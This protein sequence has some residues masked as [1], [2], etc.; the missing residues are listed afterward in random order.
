[1]NNKFKE[2]QSKFA[3]LEADLQNPALLG[4]SKKV[5]EVSQEYNELKPAME[6]IKELAGLEN[7]IAETELIIKGNDEEMREM[8][9]AEIHSFDMYGPEDAPLTIIAFG[10]TKLPVLE[11]MKWL[12]DEQITVNFL[13]VSSLL[14]FPSD[15]VAKTMQNAKKT[16][17]IE[18]NRS[19]QFE[20]IIKEHTGLSVSDRL[21]KYNGR[22]FYPEEIVA[23]VKQVVK[24]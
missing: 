1:M 8:A 16:L 22:P 24:S 14:P 2:I 7:N 21:R 13:K 17:I 18:G 3:K 4:G 12:Q 11:A 10:S 23:K 20:G 19:G 5:K 6:K 9:T 15:I